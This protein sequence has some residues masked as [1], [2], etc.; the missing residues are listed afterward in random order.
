MKKICAGQRLSKMLN[1]LFCLVSCFSC[2]LFFMADVYQRTFT[3][4]VRE[5]FAF[6]ACWF[7]VDVG[8]YLC[9]D[10]RFHFWTHSVPLLGS[11]AGPEVVGTTSSGLRPSWGCS[12]QT[13][14]LPERHE[15]P[16]CFSP[17][18]KDKTDT[19]FMF[20]PFSPHF[21]CCCVVSHH[22]MLF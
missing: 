2:V 18:V 1:A 13:L 14:P 11:I 21:S 8:A 5:D 7:C 16:G 3:I 20:L 10:K 17:G 22:A 6:G 9:K 12:K 15:V 19:Y 4:T